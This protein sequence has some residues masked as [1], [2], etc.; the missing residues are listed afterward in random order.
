MAS[1]THQTSEE[2]SVVEQKVQ[3]NIEQNPYK[4]GKQTKKETIVLPRRSLTKDEKKDFADWW[5]GEGNGKRTVAK[6]VRKHADYLSKEEQL[7]LVC[8]IGVALINYFYISENP[9]TR[10]ARYSYAQ[11]TAITQAQ[12]ANQKKKSQEELQRRYAKEQS[13]MEHSH[14][15]SKERAEEAS[16]FRS[17]ESGI[18]GSILNKMKTGDLPWEE[19][20]LSEGPEEACLW[21]LNKIRSAKLESME[22]VFGVSL[23]TLS[24]RIQRF[25][26][27]ALIPYL[28]DI[29]EDELVKD[30]EYW[31]IQ[32][33][34]LKEGQ[35]ISEQIS[36]YLQIT[37]GS[38]LLHRLLGTQ[39]NTES[40]ETSPKSVDSTGKTKKAPKKQ[41]FRKTVGSSIWM[42]RY[43]APRIEWRTLA[44]MFTDSRHEKE[45]EATIEALQQKAKAALPILLFEYVMHRNT[46]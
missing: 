45:I 46:R 6:Q 21:Y 19:F 20:L 12:T 43:T 35:D 23:K 16:A 34:W 5:E 1:N 44:E 39:R 33:G 36:A 17:V 40:E 27:S 3:S 26:T 13:H 22:Q 10:E 37:E 28:A 24:G 4:K 42:A 41:A 18:L 32:E 15:K 9:V 8:E 11:T 7:D 25:Q 2:L 14:T 30:M 29:L 38:E 31:A